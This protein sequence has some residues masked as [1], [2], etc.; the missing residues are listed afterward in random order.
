MGYF[1]TLFKARYCTVQVPF[2]SLIL[3][4]MYP[5]RH[6]P[7]DQHLY[8]FLSLFIFLRVQARDIISKTN[9]HVDRPVRILFWTRSEFRKHDWIWSLYKVYRSNTSA[10]CQTAKT[11]SVKTRI[12]LAWSFSKQR[13]NNL[14][15]RPRHLTLVSPRTQWTVYYCGFSVSALRCCGCIISSKSV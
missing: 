10:N 15:D 8:R 11:A 7:N 14:I 6:R 2:C 4:K 3:Q 1:I 5:R 12:D 13:P 9:K